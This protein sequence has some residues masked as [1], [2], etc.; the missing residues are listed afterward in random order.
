MLRKRQGTV[1][2]ALNYLEIFCHA[3]SYVLSQTQAQLTG[4]KWL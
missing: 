4:A 3:M 1:P 2:H